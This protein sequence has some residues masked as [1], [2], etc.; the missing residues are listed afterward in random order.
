MIITT[1]LTASEVGY[2]GSEIEQVDRPFSMSTVMINGELT[3]SFA[4]SQHILLLCAYGVERVGCPP[5]G[6]AY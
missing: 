1:Y 6:A 2:L 5:N 4:A 3:I